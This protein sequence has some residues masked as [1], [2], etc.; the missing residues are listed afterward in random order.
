MAIDDLL[1]EHEQSERVRSWLQK[2]ALGL[3]GGVALGLGLIAGW[4][5]WQKRHHDDRVATSALYATSIK[6]MEGDAAKAK[7]AVAALPAGSEYAA[8][9]ALQLAKVQ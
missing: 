8:L 5:W 1:N 3:I 4:Q 2:N 7:A 6:A 9:A